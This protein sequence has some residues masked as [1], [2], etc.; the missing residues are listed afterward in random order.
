[1]WI[2]DTQASYT[3]DIELQVLLGRFLNYHNGHLLYKVHIYLGSQMPIKLQI[4]QQLHSSPIPMAGHSG[5]QRIR[6]D[7]YWQV[8]RSDIQKLARECDEC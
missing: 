8:M 7:F 6:A 5:Y 2:D 3:T 4:V 1:M